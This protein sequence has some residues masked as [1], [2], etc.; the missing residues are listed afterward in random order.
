MP[1]KM[2]LVRGTVA[3]E[4]I[5]ERCFSNPIAEVMR[6]EVRGAAPILDAMRN[7]ASRNLLSQQGFERVL[8]DGSKVTKYHHP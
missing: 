1:G 5:G 4:R 3:I 8:F 7:K 6:L 2:W